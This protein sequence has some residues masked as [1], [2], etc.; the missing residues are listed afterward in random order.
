MI[1]VSLEMRFVRN[2]STRVVLLDQGHILEDG[3]PDQVFTNP[4]HEHAKQFLQRADLE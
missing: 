4:Q 1:V 2:V 3:N